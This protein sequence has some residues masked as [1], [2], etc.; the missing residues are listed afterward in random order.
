MPGSFKE[1][2]G[3]QSGYSTVREGMEDEIK[4]VSKVVGEVQLYAI[5]RTVW[6]IYC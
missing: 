4:E 2:R 1:Q 5:V 3:G 6:D